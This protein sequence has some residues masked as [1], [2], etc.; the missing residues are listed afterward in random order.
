MAVL[1]GERGLLVGEPELLGGRPDLDDVGGR[2]AGPH[3]GDGPVHVLAGPV[4]AS[5]WAGL[6]EPTAKV[7]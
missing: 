1:Q 5:R 3:Q 4:Y 2:G 6:A 7:R